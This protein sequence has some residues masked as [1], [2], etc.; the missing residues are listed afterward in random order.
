MVRWYP[1]TRNFRISLRVLSQRGQ[2][3]R[4]ANW[5]SDVNKLPS[6]LPGKCLEE[7][8]TKSHSQ[9]LIQRN[10]GWWW[11]YVKSTWFP[12]GVTTKGTT[13]TAHQANKGGQEYRCVQPVPRCPARKGRWSHELHTAPGKDKSIW[14][15][16]PMHIFLGWQNSELAKCRNSKV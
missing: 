13:Q 10:K 1:Q 3:W 16:P 7:I 5:T 14:Q 15:S 11:G 9:C 2:I 4:K 8:P 6:C 12:F